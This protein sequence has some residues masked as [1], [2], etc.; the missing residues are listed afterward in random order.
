MNMAQPQYEQQ[1]YQNWSITDFTVGQIDSADDNVIP[2][3]AAAYSSNWISRYIGSMTTRP[4]Q[5]RLTDA[6]LGG[7]IQGLHS[8]YGA[9]RRIVAASNGAVDYWNGTAWVGLKTGLDASATVLFEDCVNYMVSF[10]GVNAPWK[11]DGA[12]VTA[13][14]NAP[15]KGRFAILHKEKLFTVD[16]DTPSTLVWSNSTKPEDWPAVN[17]WD[18]KKGDG[19]EIT[20]LVKFFGEM[21]VFKRRSI[22]SLRGTSLDDFRLDEMDTRIG[23]VGRRAA[24]ADGL[25]VYFVADDGLYEFNGMKATNISKA[26]IPKLWA[27]INKQHI[28]KAAVKAWGGLIWFALP[29][30]TSTYN[31]MVIIYDPPNALTGKPGAFWPWRGI[32]ASCFIDYNSGTDVK[33][34]AGDSAA[35]YV[36]QQDTGTKDFTDTAIAATWKGKNFDKGGVAYLA[37]AKKAFLELYPNSVGKPALQVALDYGA[38]TALTETYTDDF[39][40]EYRFSATGRWRYLQPRITYT[41]IDGCHVR[42]LLIP[43]KPK[44]KPKVKAAVV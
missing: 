41:G 30:G 4:G 32:N 6:A 2:D 19:D 38:F 5:A 7:A 36:N 12:A 33:L 14:A 15:A 3:Q 42:G 21:V 27:T 20:C 37:K 11:W 29:E 8:Y 1:P 35:G 43:V 31:N 23:C 16:A 25:R 13:L 39:A 24:V 17:Y 34:Y 10:N 22:H 44:K 40:L 28:H 26:L 18:V 9:D